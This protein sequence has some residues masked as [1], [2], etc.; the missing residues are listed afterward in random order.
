VKHLE[1]QPPQ[2]LPAAKRG[3]CRAAGG[4]GHER[5]DQQQAGRLQVCA[6]LLQRVAVAVRQGAGGRRGACRGGAG[7]AGG[8][9]G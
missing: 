8:S 7:G 3:R 2:R 6:A 1:Q 9:W 5:L 4:A